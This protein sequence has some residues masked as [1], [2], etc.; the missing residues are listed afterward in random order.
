MTITSSN[1]Q[2]MEK[3]KEKYNQ[4]DIYSLLEGLFYKEFPGKIALVS[5]FGA[6][7]AILLY[8]V[9]K[10]TP[11]FPVI[12]IDTQKLFSETLAY[13]D[14][15]IRKFQLKNVKTIYPDYNDIARKDPGGDLWK[16]DPRHCCTI[17]KVL[18]LEKA[19]KDYD[20]WITGRKRYHGGMRSD[21]PRIEISDGRVKINPLFNWSQTDIHNF[22]KDNN[23]PYHP[24][25]MKGY[26][27]LGCVHCTQKTQ[28]KENV[29]GG[30]WPGEQMKECGIHLGQ[31]GKFH[32]ISTRE[33][34]TKT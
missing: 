28:D 26:T 24:L 8:L 14:L 18:P 12:F 34:K 33:D 4:T 29:R 6:E 3:I 19:L 5:S 7:A 17:R 30:R 32:R 2:K 1:L 9:S 22:F 23:I 10:I 20:A 15:L 27:S 16:M 31:D 11:D 21:L 25:V 13:R